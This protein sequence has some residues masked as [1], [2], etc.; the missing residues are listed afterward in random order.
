MS[1]VNITFDSNVFPKVVNPNPDKFPDEQAL[2]SFQIINSSIKNGYAKGFLA[3]TVFTIE[4]IKK[5]DRHKF[6]RNYNL[7]YTVTEYI[8]GDIRDNEVVRKAL[9]GMDAC[10][11]LACIS[12]DPSY[13][14]NPNLAKSIN[15][16]A[17][18]MFATEINK[19]SV[20]ALIY[21]SSSS[22]YGVK[23]E[24]N[25]TE[26][27]ICEPL[28]DY[29]KYKVMCEDIALTSILKDICLTIVRPSTVCGYSRRQR[30][31]LVVNVLTLSALTS[32]VI[33]VD[34]GDQFRPNL[35]IKDMVAS[36]KLLLETN[37]KIIDRKIY[38]IAGENLTVLR[39]AEKVQSQMK[40]S[41]EIKVVPVID[42]RSYRVSG[43]K[44]ESE[45]GFIP[46]YSVDDAINDLKEAFN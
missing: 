8:E 24:E 22:V 43:K 18:T 41:C 16:D 6:F 34:G 38:N 33:N 25:V 30:F 23:E 35:H 9:N 40:E 31:D 21:A 29:S 32:S 27:L 12:N 37:P 4:A 1:I 26:E 2:P 5:I 42:Q 13:E 17:F 46:K 36:Y 10:I 19:S 45:I 3:E 44:I 39:I 15:F 14:L 28:T 11:H 20:K 7:P